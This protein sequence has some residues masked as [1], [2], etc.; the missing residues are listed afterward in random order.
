M[1]V[2]SI[3]LLMALVGCAER[4]I[5]S[6]DYCVVDS[7][8]EKKVA[9]VVFAWVAHCSDGCDVVFPRMI[10]PGEGIYYSP[11]TENY[12]RTTIHGYIKKI[13]DL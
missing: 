2:V 8:T 5:K 9:D 7:V 12:D 11:Y 6:Y 1:K 4:P 10:R 13:E 3:V